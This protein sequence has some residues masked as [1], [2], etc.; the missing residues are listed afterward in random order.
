M[1]SKSHG[2]RSKTKNRSEDDGRK[3]RIHDVHHAYDRKRMNGEWQHDFEDA[4]IKELEDFDAL[5]DIE[6]TELEALEEFIE[7]EREEHG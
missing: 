1:A 4:E 5:H 2:W 3:A 7:P 6:D